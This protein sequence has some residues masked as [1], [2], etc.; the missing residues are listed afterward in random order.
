MQ[1]IITVLLCFSIFTLFLTP[2]NANAQMDPKVKALVSMAVYGSIGGALLGTASLAF[3]HSKR[4]IARGASLGLYAGILFGGFVIM[5]HV[6]KVNN[7]NLNPTTEDQ[8]YYPDTEQNIIYES[9]P[10][11]NAGPYDAG[12]DVGSDDRYWQEI[13]YS[14][15][16]FK[17]DDK[18]RAIRGKSLDLPLVYFNFLNYNF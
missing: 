6:A 4:A 8:D 17:K 1:K 11:Q 9:G 10:A 16:F 18:I 14:N 7:W 15:D 13:K 5:S 3:G 12:D 2:Q